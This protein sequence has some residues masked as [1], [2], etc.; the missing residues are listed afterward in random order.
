[1]NQARWVARA[2]RSSSRAAARAEL[3]VRE[4]APRPRQSGRRGRLDGDP[5]RLV[6]QGDQPKELFV[7]LGVEPRDQP[8]QAASDEPRRAPHG[9][10][11]GGGHVVDA[12]VL[13]ADAIVLARQDAEQHARRV[14]RLGEDAVHGVPE[15]GLQP[16]RDP[17]RA[18]ADAARQVDEQRLVGVH[19]DVERG[20]LPGQPAGGDGVA[21]EQADRV[22]VV[23]EVGARVAGRLRAAAGDGRRVVARVLDDADAAGA[24]EVLLPRPRVG[25]H[26]HARPEAQ[27][28]GHD[29]DR[30]PQVAGR[31]DGHLVAGEQGSRVGGGERPV[32]AGGRQDARLD[33][34]LLGVLQHLVDAAAGLDRAA[35]RQLAV[36]L[37]PEASGQLGAV[38]AREASLGLGDRD[39]RRFDDARR[40]AGLT[41]GVREVGGEA[42][43]P[44]CG[45]LDVGRREPHVAEGLGG[46][47]QGRVEPGGGLQADQPAQQRK[48][49]E[50]VV[51][52]TAERAGRHGSSLGNGGWMAVGV[53]TPRPRE[54]PAR[55]PRPGS[56]H[57]SGRP[58]W[59]CVRRGSR[60]GRRAARRRAP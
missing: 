44:R 59:R 15:D 20:E 32:V 18:A 47:A 3:P 5:V 38:V 16:E 8:A 50:P 34:H 35:D 21:Q 13:D 28:R 6:Q 55:R 24:Q 48:P 41:E 33:R 53:R 39:Q 19:G 2:R 7:G 52:R 58:G 37:G 45:V 11:V 26:V 14:R 23:D 17:A 30:Q 9:Q 56:S 22:L 29:A 54:P 27:P 57:R 31:A 40:A 60:W 1:M 36:E 10:P 49:D 25:G 46:G 51:E 4:D 12:E 43:Q 42:P